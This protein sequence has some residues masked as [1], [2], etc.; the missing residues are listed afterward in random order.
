MNK[1]CL[2]ILS[3]AA[4]CRS[5]LLSAQG[6][7]YFTWYSSEGN[8]ALKTIH[9]IGQDRKGYIWIATWDGLLRFD[10]YAFARHTLPPD[11]MTNRFV[12]LFVDV[13]DNIWSLAYD[14]NLYRFDQTS[15]TFSLFD[16][17]GKPVAKCCPIDGRTLLVVFADGGSSRVVISDDGS[18][19]A[20]V[21]EEETRETMP[22]INGV[23]RADDGALWF[24]TD[25]LTFSEKGDTLE[26]PSFCALDCAGGTFYG[27]DAGKVVRL[28]GGRRRTYSVDASAAVSSLT[29]I[30]GGD[31]LLVAT[32]DAGIFVLS[33]KSGLSR[34]LEPSSFEIGSSAKVITDKSG[35]IWVNFSMGGLDR[36][37]PVTERMVPFYDDGVQDGWNSED[38]ATAVF[39]DRQGILWVGTNWHGLMK[40]VF[41]DEYFRLV[42]PS[43]TSE[44]VSPENSVRA[45]LQDAFGRVWVGTKD[46]RLHVYDGELAHLGDL[47]LD[48]RVVSSR[49]GDV[50]GSVYSMA[51]A[52]DGTLWLGTRRDGLVE[53]VPSSPACDRYELRRYGKDEGA[54]D[55]LPGDEIF[56]LDMGEDGRMWIAAF[57][58]G[59]SYVDTGEEQLRFV[60]GRNGLNVPGGLSGRL[61]YVTHDGSGRLF[62]SGTLGL[63]VCG[64]TSCAPGDM[65]FVNMEL[66]SPAKDSPGIRDVQHLE[67]ASDGS[68]Y[69]SVYGGGFFRLPDIC[70]GTKDGLMSEFVTSSVEDGNGN[71]WIAT[72][73][74]LNK[75][76]PRTGS[77]EGFSY[78]RIGYRIRFNEGSPLRLKDG[79]ICFNTSGGVLYFNPDE[80]SNSRFVPE[81]NLLRSSLSADAK[82][83]SGKDLELD[84]QAMD[85]T[86]PSQVIY[87]YRLDGGEWTNLGNSRSLTIPH[88][89]IG[90]HLLELRSTNG[91]GVEV[92]NATKLAFVVEP[93]GWWT[94]WALCIYVTVILSVISVTLWLR[95]RHLLA[96]EPY[97]GQLHGS[98]RIFVKSMVEYM[99]AHLE[100]QSLDIP[101]IA[102]ALNVS[103]SA[104][105]EKTKS[106]LDTTP[107]EILRSL[108]FGKAQALIRAGE[109]TFTEI[110]Y[111]CGFSDV[112]YFSSSFKQR[113]G[114]TPGEYKRNVVNSRRKFLKK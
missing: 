55:G 54:P 44:V 59:L 104:L 72:D 22:V 28:S 66:S 112:H 48:G 101:K 67:V 79:S 90:R 17:G 52:S 75:Y 102:F 29:E 106:I 20:E 27:S 7:H 13:A 32:S 84:F 83:K 91:N 35:N 65:A 64:D 49:R 34:K 78:E 92:D 56:C 82:L 77:L 103:R 89:G 86:E 36:F 23:R 50:V 2:V 85:L 19:M 33:L 3:L 8:Q 71:I 45:M 9:A 46:G 88:P 73:G 53:L 114:M 37:D 38:R 61:R 47:S 5:V 1:T 4:L 111:R 24:L 100:E 41:N 40:V 70:L 16:C 60:S 26:F 11:R 109:H 12:D 68:I 58:A 30:P 87:Y 99:T 21:A 93:L 51:Q 97:Y 31:K 80:I 81:M 15:G 98:D 95:R 76:N 69:A 96:R 39:A 43:T 14:N 63:F 113:F 62:V 10:G 94:W 107:A 57:D 18:Y 42:S 25:S 74:G 110:A 105:F 6:P 108:R